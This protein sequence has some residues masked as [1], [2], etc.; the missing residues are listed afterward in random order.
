MTF[1]VEIGG[2]KTTSR[3]TNHNKSSSG[4]KKMDQQVVE[5]VPDQMTPDI[6][7]PPNEIKEDT[8]LKTAGIGLEDSAIALE[9]VTNDAKGSKCLSSKPVDQDQLDL[10]MEFQQIIRDETKEEDA[11]TNDQGMAKKTEVE[12]ALPAKSDLVLQK[13]KLKI[14]PNYKTDQWTAIVFIAAPQVKNHDLAIVG[15]DQHLGKW[16]QPKGKFES[17]VQIGTDLYIFKGIVPVPDKP[18]FK[19]VHVNVADDKIEY[20]GEGIWDNR[21]EELLPDSWNFF[22]FK[23]KPKSVFGK[24][25][26]AVKAYLHKSETK[27]KIAFNFFRIVFDH[28][29]ET[30]LPDWDSA[31]EFISECLAKVKQATGAQSS[32]GFLQFLNKWFEDPEIQVNFDQLFLLIVGAC[33]MEVYSTKMKQILEPNRKE[34]SRYLHK[35]GGV[36]RKGQDLKIILERIACYAGPDF[37]WILFRLNRHLDALRKFTREEVSESIFKTL[38]EIPEVLL[39]IPDSRNR[40]VDHLVR[41]NDIDEIYFHLFPVFEKNVSYQQILQSLLLQRLFVHKTSVEDVVKILR[42]EFMEKAFRNIS[43]PSRGIT[44]TENNIS[45]DMV[46]LKSANLA[47]TANSK[48]VCE[49]SR[50]NRSLSQEGLLFEEAIRTVFNRK[51]SDAAKVACCIPDYMLPI[52]M[53]IVENMVSHTLDTHSHFNRDDY[54]YFG[55]LDE[56]CFK[57]F[58]RAKEKI[59]A[60]L[61]KMTVDHVKSGSFQDIPTIKLMLLGLAKTKD[62]P[63]LER[64][65]VVDLQKAIGRLPRKFFNNLYAT[66]K[67]SGTS[68]EKTLKVYRKGATKAIVEQ[69]ENHFDQL[70]DILNRVRDR[71]VPLIELASLQDPQVLDCLKS[72]GF[73]DRTQDELR[74]EIEELRERHNLYGSLYSRFSRSEVMFTSQEG[75]NEE[76]NDLKEDDSEED[77]NKENDNEENVSKPETRHILDPKEWESYLKDV[78]SGRSILTLKDAMNLQVPLQLPSARWLFRIKESDLFMEKIWHPMVKSSR[79][80]PLCRNDLQA[81]VIECAA[82]WEGLAR[83]IADGS[84]SFIYMDE[85]VKLQSDSNVLSKRHLQMQSVE[86]VETAYRNFK[87]LQEL[88]HLIGPFVAA[89]RFFTIHERGPID[90]LHNFIKTNLLKNWDTTTLAQIAETGIL[91]VVNEELNIDPERPETRNVMQFISSLVTDEN[92]SP[93]IEWLR[94]KTEKDMEAM[95]K[96]LQGTLLVAYG[97][98]Q[99]LRTRI[100]PFL[101]NEFRTYQ[102]LLKVVRD[103]EER[104]A[105]RVSG[106]VQPIDCKWLVNMLPEIQAA[107]RASVISP[108]EDAKE[109][110]TKLHQIVIDPKNEFYSIEIRLKPSGLLS[111]EELKQAF[112]LLDMAAVD[113]GDDNGELIDRIRRNVGLIE[114]LSEVFRHLYASGCITFTFRNS[115]TIGLADLETEIKVMQD[116]LEKWTDHWKEIEEMPFLSLFSRGYLLQLADLIGKNEIDDVKSILKIRLPAG[117]SNIDALVNELIQQTPSIDGE[118]DWLSVAQLFT[119]LRQLHQL[120]KAVFHQKSRELDLPPFLVSYGRTLRSHF[121]DKAVVILNVP[122]ELLVGSSLAAFISLTNQPIEPS[123]ILFVTTNTDKPEV[124][125]FMKLWSVG[126]AEADF[127]IILHVER[128]TAACACAV[129]EGVD[130][131]LPERRA[132][133]LLLAQHHHRVQSTKSLGARLGVVSDR[134]LEVNFTAD[135][136]RQCFASLLPNAANLHFFT[137]KLPGCGKSQ[138]AMQK[139]ANQ[140]SSPDYYRICVRTGSV[141]ELLASLKKIE[142]LS[143]QSRKSAT[144]LHLDVAH[145]VSF[146]FNDIL[147][148]LLV[149]GALFDPKKAKLGYWVISPRTSIALEFASP[150]GVD[151]FP[152]IAYLG[153]H[154]VCECNKFFFSYDLAAMPRVLG[155]PVMI[156]RS[157]AL[158]AIGKFLQVKQAG[159]KGLRMWDDICSLPE[160]LMID[161]LPEDTT[162]D[163]LV[164][165]FQHEENRNAPTFSA[166]NAM[167]SFLYRHIGAMITSMWFNGSAVYLF[168]RD[169]LAGV[170][171]LNVFDLLLKVA[172][173][174]INRCWSLTNQGKKL[175]DMDWTNRQRAMF[176]LGLNENGFIT[177]M[178]VVGRDANALKSMFHASLLPIL[179]HQCLHFQELRGFRNLMESREGAEVILNAMRSLLLLDGT[180]TSAVKVYQ[181]D[182]HP[183]NTAASQRL[184]ELVGQDQGYVLTGD[185]IT[186]MMFALYR[187]R[188]GL[189]VVAFGEA[190]V[191]KSALFRFLIQTLLGHAFE[192]CNVNSGT[193]IEDVEAIIDLSV[194]IIARNPDAQ[195]FLFFD[196]MN[197]ADPPVIAFLKELMLDRHCHGTVLPDNLHL[198]AAANPYRH[199]KEADK[200]AAVGLAFRF[201]QGESSGARSDARDLVYRVNELPVAFY[202]HIYDFGR[203]CDEAENTYIEEICQH[204]L[205]RPS[206]HSDWVKWF[207][208]VVQKSHSVARA[209]SVDPESA[210]SLR[211]AARAVQLFH[212]FCLAPAGQKIS[213]GDMAVA[214]DL[215]I[216]LV[217]AFRFR[218]RK[219][220]LRQVFG[221]DQSASDNMT[222]V[223]RIIAEMLY[224]QA[225]GASIGSGAIAFN[226]A[227]CENLFALYVCVLN[228]IFLIIVGRP[229]SSKSLS[230]EIL[231]LVLSPGNYTLRQKLGDLPAITELYFQ[232]SPMSTSSGFKALFESAQRLSVDPKTMLAMVV[233]DE[234]GLT[235]MSPEKPIKVL[236]SELERQSVLT[237]GEKQQS[238]YSVVALSNWV[239]DAAQVNRGILILRAQ[240]NKEDL[241]RSAKQLA[242]SLLVKYAEKSARKR[243]LEMLT[244]SLE[245]VVSTYQELDKR[246]DIGGGHFFSMRDFFFC[247]KNFVC[248]V[249]ESYTRMGGLRDIRISRH[250]LIQSAVRNFGGHEKARRLVRN[251]MANNLE[252]KLE[253]IPVTSPLDLIVANIQ[254]SSKPLSIHIARHLMILNRSMIGLQL[255]NRYVKREL[256]D[257]TN[258]NVLFGSCFPGDLQVTAVTRKLRQVEQAIRSGG[259]LILCHADQLFESL[260]MVL[261][262]Q[263]WAQGEMRMTQIA[264]GPSIR[265][266]A[267]PDGP[268]RII[269]LQD[270]DVALNRELMSP[271]VLS[272]FEKHELRPSHLLDDV[273][274]S[275][276]DVIE[277]H[278]LWFPVAETIKRQKFIYGYHEESFAALALYLQDG[279]IPMEL[280]ETQDENQ[281]SATTIW[282]R[283]TNPMS[284]I[285]LERDPSIDTELL[286][287]CRHYRHNFVL[288][289]IDEAL[290]KVKS[291]RIVLMTNTLRHLEIAFAVSSPYRHSTI[292]L[293]EILTELELVKL[294]ESINDEDLADPYFCLIVQYDAVTGPIEQFQLAKYEIEQRFEKKKCRVIFVVHV[295]PRPVN[296]HWVFSFGDGWDYC[297]VDEVVRGGQLDHHRIPLGEFVKSASDQTLSGFIEK[298]STG[299]FKSLLLEMLGPVLQT[300]LATLR[301]SLGQFYSGVR[302]ALGLPNNQTLIKLMKECLLAQLNDSGI[303]WNVVD[304]VN[305]PSFDSSSSLTEGLWGVFKHK[306]CNPL[307]HFLLVSDIWRISD[308]PSVTLWCDFVTANYPDRLM[309]LNSSD[310]PPQIPVGFRTCTQPFGRLLASFGMNYG[311]RTE[312]RLN[313]PL[314]WLLKRVAENEDE[315]SEEI[316][317]AYFLDW[318]LLRIPPHLH[319]CLRKVP[320]SKMSYLI[321]SLFEEQA[322]FFLDWEHCEAEVIAALELVSIACFATADT[323]DFWSEATSRI[324]NWKFFTETAARLSLETLASADV[325]KSHKRFMQ[326]ISSIELS[327]ALTNLLDRGEDLPRVWLGLRITKRI[328][329]FDPDSDIRLPEL[330][331][332]TPQRLFDSLTDLVITSVVRPRMASGGQTNRIVRTADL[333]ALLK[334][335]S[336]CSSPEELAKI[337]AECPTTNSIVLHEDKIAQGDI[338][339][340]CPSCESRLT[341]IGKTEDDETHPVTHL[342]TPSAKVIN[343]LFEDYQ[344]FMFFFERVAEL[345]IQQRK[346][347]PRDIQDLLHYVLSSD[348]RLRVSWRFL[349]VIVRSVL[350]TRSGKKIMDDLLL[351]IRCNRPS[352]ELNVNAYNVL[353]ALLACADQDIRNNQ[354]AEPGFDLIEAAMADNWTVDRIQRLANIRK[355]IAEVENGME[356]V[357]AE[358]SG[359]R[360]NQN[361]QALTDSLLFFILRFFSSEGDQIRLSRMFRNPRIAEELNHHKVVN[362]FIMILSPLSLGFDLQSATSRTTEFQKLLLD[363]DRFDTE[364]FQHYR[365]LREIQPDWAPFIARLAYHAHDIFV[366]KHIRLLREMATNLVATS[367]CVLPGI[368]NHP[369]LASFTS[370]AFRWFVCNCGTLNCVGNCGHPTPE[371]ICVNCRVA[372]SQASHHPR[373]GVR[374]A[375]ARDFEPPT[376]IHVTRNATRTPTF[377]VRNCSPVVTRFALLLNS[378]ALM[379]AALNRQTDQRDIIRL[380]E[381]LPLTERQQVE[382]RQS[383]IRLLSNHIIVHLDL[384]CQLLVASRPQLAMTDK[385]RIGH[386][387]LHK[388]LASQDRSF[389]TQAADFANGTQA[390]ETFENGLT[391]LL[392]QQVNLAEELDHIAGQSDAASKVLRQSFL[393]NETSHW[394]YARRV[395]ADRQTLQ[396]ELARNGQ[397]RKTL[398]FLNFLLDDEN[399][400]PKLNALQYLG[401]A[402]RFVALVRT[403][404]AGEITLEEANR[405]TIAQ[406]LEKITDIVMQKVVLLD[407]GRPVSKREHVMDLFDGFKQLWDRFSQLQNTEKKTFLDY[408][409]CQ[410]VD[411]NV[412]PKTI[413]DQEAPLILIL[414]GNE[415]PE[416]TFSCQLL[417]HAV[418]AA[419]SIALT[420]FIQ[421]LCRGGSGRV[422]LSC[423]SSAALTDFDESLYAHVSTEE[424]DNF[425]RDHVIDRSTLQLAESFAMAAILGPAGSTI[426]EELSLEVIPEFVFKDDM[427]SGNFLVSLERRSIPWQPSTIPPQLQELILADLEKNRSLAEARSILISVITHLHSN[428]EPLV[429]SKVRKNYISDVLEELVQAEVLTERHISNATVG[430]LNRHLKLEVRHAFG[431]LKAIVA[432]MKGDDV[433]GG[434]VRE[435]WTTMMSERLAQ[436]TSQKL[437]ADAQPGGILETLLEMVNIISGTQPVPVELTP[438]KSLLYAIKQIE[439]PEWDGIP[440]E[441]RM[442]HLGHLLLI[443]ES[444]AKK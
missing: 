281:H 372:L 442:E 419:S 190:G 32:E 309:S 46:L 221:N 361:D 211:D 353:R 422:R 269:A 62:I 35:F 159:Q 396:L 87:N 388:L 407:R 193:S 302:I 116:Q 248:S 2:R 1:I 241:L 167:A 47:Q 251:S 436:L 135:Q 317:E 374:R 153:K 171:K 136:L 164:D 297:F 132:K 408:F 198:M 327:P 112:Q 76:E 177:G 11:K 56:N 145:S 99:T 270:T 223:S 321:D 296:M 322:M 282:M 196:E 128:L 61:L 342:R 352:V 163:L 119:I 433:F 228:G 293:F 290:H 239:V 324:R 134:L 432:R 24:A 244:E 156:N 39:D 308:R 103:S 179:Q 199:L 52:A 287:E 226:D 420:D 115:I 268:F 49:P 429:V 299:S 402:L 387:L 82:Q 106:R 19:F 284:M 92:R 279:G 385:F 111:M 392:N 346:N 325:M 84:T 146:E 366:T 399:W 301:A 252:M 437:R 69:L 409:E 323:I 421:P 212:W 378:L 349:T 412:R 55:E 41:W 176:L 90:A 438:D 435:G 117:A 127:F 285:K 144:Y 96:I 265:A 310:S 236:H 185:N 335:T 289:N 149:H 98:L 307:A 104:F 88:R 9:S 245:S 424:V 157:N 400:M 249:F 233:L 428:T 414:A 330:Q 230:V 255:L 140:L 222:E 380:F 292:Q 304:A 360:K 151:E 33:K 218:K 160:I 68:V 172:N 154:Y 120:I 443:V 235:D 220:F 71:R 95:G 203:L 334:S 141:D 288:E 169:D 26:E 108:S 225:H 333:N 181:L 415:L 100:A 45:N 27:E 444:V 110:L 122:R 101:Q 326:S 430:V 313:E 214:A 345:F 107:V 124:E 201:A 273:G 175:T 379:N 17:I 37:W 30:I 133:L 48:S 237:S 364:E 411:I 441:L 427:E 351:T 64:A 227:L 23:P 43:V 121:I 73:S 254:D 234:L 363:G 67:K 147:L 258:W 192:V 316:K 278:P 376:G 283:A 303:T 354:D 197:T 369:Y 261:N 85:I 180:A 66:V 63:F 401:E 277:S 240:A 266:I 189:P 298:M 355:Q 291:N 36:K 209:L 276:R 208:S 397:L 243:I 406:G 382:N 94:Q 58:P 12:T 70:E 384:L 161:P 229:G 219:M 318:F 72:F 337:L 403:V 15:E 275:Y 232:C 125:R 205:P 413:L 34:F 256:D 348:F 394:A 314:Q 4:G 28:T 367:Q 398:P 440:T 16:K 31:M 59:S 206:Y 29:L 434:R 158:V 426:A 404:L 393:H 391:R 373:A 350:S 260:Y 339:R 80:L 91:K 186:K 340:H 386:L 329:L 65:K 14:E 184:N 423:S 60:I 257:G 224:E 178:N 381:T 320:L 105:Q 300:S 371:S 42:S 238:P 123:R 194:K 264:L 204:G 246:E 272:R 118:E 213:Q 418:E 383:L 114:K 410:Q 294:L 183:K 377:A 8:Q 81:F 170:F 280:E 97:Q 21:T 202:D 295:D 142:T 312:P 86:G 271:A 362:D 188:C 215:T 191:G 341:T 44:E 389:L 356:N 7:E 207:V 10:T 138:Q 102:D 425:I 319:R 54:R 20:E 370:E 131:V 262:Q 22:V 315:N 359:W 187:I 416:T 263:Y 93:L 173:D 405:M 200:E 57:S 195:V 155:Q 210:V 83:R 139:A 38:Q 331:V 182:S 365:A 267:L 332:S 25:W 6:R 343:S 216:Y 150:F 109:K 129:R 74:Q 306:I 368:D 286:D 375:T 395:F 274:K 5:K 113:D 328:L 166:L 126:K 253:V 51:L 347:N 13:K 152:V 431:L 338:D 311:Q 53:P 217:Y 247:V 344:K 336:S 50:V 18:N 143:S 78:D 259:V 358:W 439:G 417:S 89:L 231:K 77:D 390:R 148:S 162:F 250:L 357:I 130:R 165:S 242:D 75:T 174:S 168:E 137:S 3:S 40:V 305:D 79:T